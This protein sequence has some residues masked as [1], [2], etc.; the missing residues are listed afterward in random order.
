M[1]LRRT[2]FAEVL[3][4][5]EE[6]VK[7]GDDVQLRKVHRRAHEFLEVRV[8]NL[9]HLNA[10]ERVGELQTWVQIWCCIADLK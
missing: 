7:N 8:A 3:D 5:A 1:T 9:Q 2:G 10:A 4:S 6:V